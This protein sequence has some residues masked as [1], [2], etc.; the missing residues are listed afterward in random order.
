MRETKF[1]TVLTDRPSARA[2]CAVAGSL[3]KQGEHLAFRVGEPVDG[4]GMGARPPVEVSASTCAATPPK[5]AAPPASV[6]TAAAIWSAVA[7]LRT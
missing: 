7:S 6:R 3:G 2:I 1:W 4:A 5:T